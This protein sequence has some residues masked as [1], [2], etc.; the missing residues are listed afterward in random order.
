MRARAP[1]RGAA[2]PWHRTKAP[3][4]PSSA[5]TAELAPA[6]CAAA[7]AV[8]RGHQPAPLCYRGCCWAEKLLGGLTW[9][10]MHRLA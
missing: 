10:V 1:D 4:Q 5:T 9:T 3:R 6:N 2:H 7:A 8:A